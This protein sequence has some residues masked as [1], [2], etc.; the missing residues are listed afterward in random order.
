[1]RRFFVKEEHIINGYAYIEG[2]D[3]HHILNVLR[4]S[5]GVQIIISDR[6][7]E[8]LTVIEEISD[9][10]VKL[11]IIEDIQTNSESSIDITLYQGLPKADKMEL[12]VQKCTELGIRS[13]VPVSTRYSVINIDETNKVK[14]INRWQKISYEAAKQSG[15]IIV[16]DVCMPV[17]FKEAIDKISEYD[18]CLIPYEKEKNTGIKDILKSSGYANKI[19]V[20]IGS[21]GGFSEEEI[22]LAIEHGAKPVTLGPRILRT[23]TA[24]IVVCSIIMYELGDIGVGGFR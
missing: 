3:A 1:M 10:K 19:A 15:R 11:K 5:K 14:K 20:F 17:T 18:L 13:F 21:E 23:E 9:D 6:T 4:L 24:G 7:K 12:I 22:M 2:K 8:Y 16:P